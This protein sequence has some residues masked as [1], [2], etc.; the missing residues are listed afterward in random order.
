MG[1]VD[2]KKNVGLGLAA[3]QLWGL[4]VAARAADERDPIA[5]APASLATLAT[6]VPAPVSPRGEP[7]FDGWSSAADL[8]RGNGRRTLA[9]FPRNV[10][11][12]FAGVLSPDNAASLI[13]GASLAAAG[14]L[15]DARATTA[16]HGQCVTCGKVGGRLGGAGAVPAV[17]VLFLAG[18]F[19]PQGTFRASTYDFAQAL[20]VSGAWTGT[21]KYSIHRRRPDGSD[22]LSL[23][24]GH[25]SA[26]F[27]LA[28]VA[29]RH[30]G[31]R[32]GV[33]GYLLAAGIGLSRVE[34]NRHNLSDVVAGA[35]LGLV[36][37]RTV[38]RSNGEAPGGR[39][40]RLA[41][42][43]ASDPQG[44]GVGLRLSASW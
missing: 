17:G 32:V 11:R 23:P 40:R 19:A 33:P 29:E 10:A 37:G 1:V 14:H 15:L 8:P 21:L 43:P 28:T 42:T 9:A 3:L 2:L 30:Y 6:D 25:A 27:S 12:S 4:A 24:S 26:A 38:T 35:A 39:R 34:S 44:A 31:W 7:V 18:R 20:A 36:V 16:L 5:L 41:L 13:A 22:D